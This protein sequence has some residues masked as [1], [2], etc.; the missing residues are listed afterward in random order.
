VIPQPDF[1]GVRI[2]IERAKEHVRSLKELV[3]GFQ[4]SEPYR[5]I[6]E[7]DPD[8]GD[9]VFKVKVSGQPPP[10]WG[11]IAG[12]AIHNLRSSLD[13]LVCELVRANG[14]EVTDSTGFL[15]SKSAKAFE[16][17]HL[18]K[19]KG[20][21]KDAMRLIKEVK[22]YKGGDEAFWRLHRL[23]IADKHKLLIPVGVAYR[24]VIL[25]AARAFDDV[26]DLPPVWLSP[27]I[28]RCLSLLGPPTGNTLSKMAQYSSG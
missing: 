1:T 15:I 14:K 2:K 10:Y 21:P 24:S 26:P 11:A 3:R 20:A 17:G 22:P 6:A 8:T 23:D 19:I 12:D 27:K 25:D 5:I 28:S 4:Q 16:S 7:D 9:L 18:G 13:L